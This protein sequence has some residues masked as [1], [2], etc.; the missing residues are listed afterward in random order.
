V[1]SIL[2]SPDRAVSMSQAARR[3]ARAYDWDRIARRMIEH[4]RACLNG[5][6]RP[7]PQRSRAAAAPRAMRVGGQAISPAGPAV[8][9]A[10]EQDR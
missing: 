5:Q 10:E 9:V 1:E 4:Y 6:E 3:L 8:A 2:S 7:E